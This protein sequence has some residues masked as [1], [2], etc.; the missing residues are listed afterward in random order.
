MARPK[1]LTREQLQSRKEQAERFTRDVLGDEERADEI[2]DE[3]LEDY[4][5]RRKIRLSNPTQWRKGKMPKRRELSRA[6]LEDRVA[7]LEAENEGLLDQLSAI[8]DIL[9]EDGQ[10]DDEDDSGEE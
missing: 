5:E 9:D 10:E 4:A 1:V 6:E 3:D 8:G 2:A 7:E